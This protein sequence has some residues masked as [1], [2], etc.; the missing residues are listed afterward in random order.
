MSF[1][2]ELAWRGAISDA[3]PGVDEVLDAGK[4]VGYVGFDPSA[5]SLHVGS[6]LPVLCLARMQKHGHTP[7]AIAGG[8][9]GLIGDPS[10]KCDER[11]LLTTEQVEQNLVGIREQLSR[12]LDFDCG[13]NSATL[14]NN[15]DW[16]CSISLMDFLRDIAKHFTV[17]TMLKKESISRRIESEQG[18]SFTEFGYMALQAYD[19]LV[20]YDRYNCTLQMGGSDQW[21]NILAGIDLIQRMRGA[22]VHGLVGPLLETSTGAKF[23]KTEAGTV[24]LDAKRTSPY[25][26]YQY[27]VNADDRDVVAYL[28][29]FTWLSRDEIAE[30]EK[31]VASAPESREAQKVLARE[32]TGM[33]HGGEAA[34]RAE[35]SAGF[36][37]S[38]ELNKLTAS[39]IM[40]A[41]GD[42]PQTEIPRSVFEGEGAELSEVLVTAGIATSKSDARR[43][44][45][46]GGIYLNNRRVIDPSERLALDASIDGTLFLL[47]KGKRNYHVLR[48]A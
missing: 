1:Y 23:G 8:G 39:E 25:Q 6:L 47:R 12:F 21:G 30:L 7:I 33:V 26:L 48:I 44:I 46:G 5:D 27:W 24:W 42:A 22:K 10:G 19:F 3:T 29:Q 28:K 9:T 37:F 15:A 41:V 2:D 4:V 43:T 35:R 38:G 14:L 45:E 11:Q 13:G 16:L 40:D 18:I 36:F 20:L 31:S 32:I 34:E 17:N